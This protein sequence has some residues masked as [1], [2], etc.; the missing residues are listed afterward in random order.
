MP[1]G[2]SPQEPCHLPT[3]H[4]EWTSAFLLALDPTTP[5]LLGL[6]AVILRALLP[7]GR[8]ALGGVLVETLALTL[9]PGQVAGVHIA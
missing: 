8:P 5:D 3:P 9:G 2:H 6:F 4:P 1:L 7:R